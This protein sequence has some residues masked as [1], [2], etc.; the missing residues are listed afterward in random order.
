M[1]RRAASGWGYSAGWENRTIP[2]LTVCM[3]GNES[4]HLVLFVGAQA[5]GNSFFLFL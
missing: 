2:A 1:Q 5:V 4:A 3:K